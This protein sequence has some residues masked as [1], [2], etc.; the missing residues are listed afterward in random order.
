MSHAQLIQDIPLQ[1]VRDL[2]EIIK[3]VGGLVVLVVLINNVHKILHQQPMRLVINFYLV[4]LLKV[5]DVLKILNCV[6][7][8]RAMKINVK[9]LKEIYNLVFVRTIV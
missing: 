3:D 1:I 8:I 2:R 7:L 5:L 9:Y 4:V 6:L